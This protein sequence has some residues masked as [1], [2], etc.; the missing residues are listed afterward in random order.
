MRLCAWTHKAPGMRAPIAGRSPAALTLYMGA[1]GAPF[2]RCGLTLA[3]AQ[4]LPSTRPI[5]KPHTVGERCAGSVVIV[6]RRSEP[7]ALA[8]CPLPQ[9]LIFTPS[10]IAAPPSAALCFSRRRSQ[11][12]VCLCSRCPASLAIT[13]GT[14][15]APWPPP[16]S[17]DPL[18]L[19]ARRLYA[20]PPPL[21]RFEL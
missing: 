13:S 10:T 11:S 8:P 7:V 21:R 18:P 15:P 5:R 17:P 9:C 20:P 6:W 12:A 16:R 3:T 19:P 4:A 2:S 1:H 14:V